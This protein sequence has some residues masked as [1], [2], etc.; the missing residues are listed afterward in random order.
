MKIDDFIDNYEEEYFMGS[1][2]G[3]F[4][5]ERGEVKKMLKDLL[6]LAYNKAKI[7]KVS[8][9]GSYLDATVDKESILNIL[10]E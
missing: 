6:K 3:D 1:T 4:A 10:E 5:F 2:F 7:K 8:N 9:S